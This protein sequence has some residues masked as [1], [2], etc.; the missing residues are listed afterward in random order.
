MKHSNWQTLQQNVFQHMELKYLIQDDGIYLTYAPL[1]EKTANHV[2][3]FHAAFQFALAESIGGIVVFENRADKTY[4][5]L[6][7]SVSMDFKKPAAT[8]LYARA[9]FNGDDVPS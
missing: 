7:K 4:T 2:N 1:N 9:E 6:L 8:D 5:P 3:T